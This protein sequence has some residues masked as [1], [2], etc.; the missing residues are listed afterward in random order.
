VY[1]CLVAVLCKILFK[2]ILKIV[3]KIVSKIIFKIQNKIVFSKY[4]SKKLFPCSISDTYMHRVISQPIVVMLAD[5][6][7]LVIS[8][9]INVAVMNKYFPR[10]SAGAY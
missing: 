3:N 2:T 9:L 8:V 5:I 7:L 6:E 4:F 10:N 1:T